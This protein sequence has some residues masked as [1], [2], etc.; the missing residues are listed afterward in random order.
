MMKNYQLLFLS[1]TVVLLTA[2]GSGGSGGSSSSTAGRNNLPHQYDV[3]PELKQAVRDSLKYKVDWE[4]VKGH[5]PEV[6]DGKGYNK[7]DFIYLTDFDLGET[8]HNFKT[9]D[10]KEAIIKGKLRVY[11]LPYSVIVADKYTDVTLASNNPDNSYGGFY[12]VGFYM[13][14][15]TNDLPKTGSAD[16]VGKSFYN[17]ETGDFK[18][19]VNFGE[20][21]VTSG[22]ITGL[23]TGK[24]TFKPGRIEDMSYHYDNEIFGMGLKGKAILANGKAFEKNVDVTESG[25]EYTDREIN[26]KSILLDSVVRLKNHKIYRHSGIVLVSKIIYKIY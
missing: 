4:P 18:L 2:C 25:T 26:A 6:I 9:T 17:D 5:Q 7:G 16:Y 1:I 23:T 12:G 10:D 15:L 3:K 14:Y 21:A 13:G 19:S 11:R 8:E 20:K 24:V 22:E